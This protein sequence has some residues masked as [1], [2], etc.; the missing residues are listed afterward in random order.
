MTQTTLVMEEWN[1]NSTNLTCHG[2]I[3]NLWH[4]LNLS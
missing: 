2:K 1:A 3:E 4:K